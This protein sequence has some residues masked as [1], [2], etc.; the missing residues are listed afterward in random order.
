MKKDILIIFGSARSHGNT[1]M[2]ADFLLEKLPTAEIMN[3][4]D[5]DFSGYDYEHKN[6]KD[7]FLKM[8]EHML[9][10]EK[11]VFCTPVYW[12]SMSSIVKR[13]L[14]RWSDLVTIRKEKGRGLAGKKLFALCCS[15][16]EEEHEG[17]FMPFEKTAGYL[18]MIYGG[19]VHTY[20]VDEKI[21]EEVKNQLLDFCDKIND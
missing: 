10:F 4:N 20:D 5:F 7:D 18:D 8:A 16:D 3:L 11:I 1:R 9:T 12:Y 17:F 21:P 15:S 2:M 14:D 6:E 13:F 19:N